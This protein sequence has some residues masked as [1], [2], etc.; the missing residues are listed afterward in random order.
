MSR[1]WVRWT[2]GGLLVLFLS[3]V[4]W[5]LSLEIP[6]R[7]RRAERTLLEAAARQGLSVR[8][9]A[10]K[11]HL[12]RL[13]VSIDNVFLRDALADL[14]LGSA[15]S[16]DVSLSPLRFLTGELPVSRV[17]IRNFR[18]EA[19]ER[20]RALHARWTAGRG[21]PAVR[22]RSRRSRR[23][24]P[25]RRAFCASGSSGR[26][27][28]RRRC[29]SPARSTRGNGSSRRMDRGRWIS[30]NGSRPALRRLRTCGASP[31]WGRWNSPSP[32]T[33]RGTIRKG[34]PASPSAMPGSRA[35]RARKGRRGARCAGGVLAPAL[36]ARSLGGGG[37]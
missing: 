7:V 22:G 9:D 12:L 34:R 30:R 10:L 33:A 25:T 13:H 11:L 37:V 32:P 6:E 29:A 26:P 19:G 31:G 28:I 24:F 20:N 1:R 18:L 5:R 3:V 23:T 17:R 15:G 8:Y 2:G 4:G 14:P 27:V 35:P 21:G 36:P 16:V